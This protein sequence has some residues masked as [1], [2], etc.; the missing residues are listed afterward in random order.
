MRR[1]VTVVLAATALL[2]AS[3]SSV[4]SSG[5][6]TVVG[7]APTARPAQ[8]EEGPPIRRS[9]TRRSADDTPVE[10]VTGFLDAEADTTLEGTALAQDYLESK[11]VWVPDAETL[12]YSSK[13]VDEVPSFGERSGFIR[14]TYSLLARISTDPKTGVGEYRPEVRKL[15]QLIEVR[16]PDSEW[17]I[18]TLPHGRR[19]DQDDLGQVFRRVVPYYF[20]DRD[21]ENLVPDPVFLLR[22]S[23][24]Q[25]QRL[26]SRLV[27]GPTPVLKDFLPRQLFPPGAALLT[28][29]EPKDKIVELTFSD[30]LEL[31]RFSDRPKIIAQIV[32]TLTGLDSTIDAVTI[33]VDGKP[34]NFDLDKPDKTGIA[35]RQA[36]W[37]E[38]DP[39]AAYASRIAYFN[40][41]GTVGSYSPSSV[42]RAGRALGAGAGQ[43]AVDREDAFVAVTAP[44]GKQQELR[45]GPLDAGALLPQIAAATLTKPSWGTDVDGVWVV[46]Q[47]KKQPPQ[48]F[49]VPAGFGNN[50]EIDSTELGTRVDAFEVA[51]DGLRVAAIIERDGVR[52]LEIGYIART[53]FE[54]KASRVGGFRKV[55]SGRAMTARSVSWVDSGKV[56]F[57]GQPPDEAPQVFTVLV[58]GTGR[59]V[60]SGSREIIKSNRALPVIQPQ[61]LPLSVR[62]ESARRGDS[63][64]V[65]NLMLVVEGRSIYVHRGSGW[66]RETARSRHQ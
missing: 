52:S 31:A 8:A 55:V 35:H 2:G 37:A 16:R 5:P 39:D 20:A 14:V 24:N 41:D 34:F 19:I 51:P 49:T 53:F 54:G 9:G 60:A 15:E 58:D 46:A 17:L 63:S 11:S 22:H 25:I 50:D 43:P 4:P 62:H 32:W 44:A 3:C 30:E 38:Y 36:A 12:V 33:K 59:E 56:M 64:G 23:S 45:V 66:K 48:L 61:L 21:Y 29:S 47:Q 65:D 42:I 57:V 18:A 27:D 40:Q 1:F 6:A 10:V 7:N 26:V 13:D 28:A